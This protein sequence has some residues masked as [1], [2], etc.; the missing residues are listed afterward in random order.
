MFKPVLYIITLLATLTS[1]A[2]ENLVPNG[3]FEENNWYPNY[4]NGFFI[5]A[6][7]YWTMPTL[8]SSDYFNACSTD[9][10]G[11]AYPVNRQH[12]VDRS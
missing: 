1:N 6:C 9:S 11:N 2:Q 4:A 5:T 7:K 10:I 12:K 8:V 3:S